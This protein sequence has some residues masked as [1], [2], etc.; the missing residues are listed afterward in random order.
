MIIEQVNKYGRQAITIV[1]ELVPI[2]DDAF[3]RIWN[4]IVA[5]KTCHDHLKANC[6]QDYT[7]EINGVELPSTIKNEDQLQEWYEYE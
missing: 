1:G 7:I 3:M 2:T 5:Y 4:V 6:N